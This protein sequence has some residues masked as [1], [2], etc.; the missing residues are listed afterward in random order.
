[1]KLIRHLWG[2]NLSDGIKPHL[3]NWREIGYQGLEFSPRLVLDARELRLL[4]KEE[5]IVWV[6]QVFSNLMEGGGSVTQHLKS[7]R[8]QI[9]ECLDGMPQFFNAHTGSD[10]WS[11]NE[12]EDFYGVA[13]K[14]E[15][16][17]G[18]VLSHATH[19]SRYFGNPWNTCYLLGRVPDIKL[20]CDFSHWV[21]VAERLLANADP[22]FFRVA[23]NCHHLHAR[24]GYE[25]GPQVPDPRDPQRNTHLKVHERWW[26][27]V[28]SA[29]QA[30][31]IDEL[32]LTPEF[33]PP[34][35]QHTLR[36]TQQP[37]GDLEA[38]CDWMAT[39][40]VERFAAWSCNGEQDAHSNEI[41]S[42]DSGRQ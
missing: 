41:A 6:P 25:Q 35:Y 13:G 34:P 20:T 10:A 12:A 30:Q 14:L 1:M 17:L 28:W 7:L 16:E 22:I 19:R 27:M 36:F 37:V 26:K 29:R 32:T 5:G 8:E 39:R 2:V 9:V 23:Q 21:C 15:A 24:V 33:G 38:I 4:L 42:S 3:S 31:G 11:L 40:Q 18:V